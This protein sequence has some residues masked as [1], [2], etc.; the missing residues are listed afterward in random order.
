MINMLLFGRPHSAVSRTINIVGKIGLS[1]ILGG[2]LMAAAGCGGNSRSN[3]KVTATVDAAVKT[4]LEDYFTACFE[5]Q[6]NLSYSKMVGN[7]LADNDNTQLNEAFRENLLSQESLFNSRIDDYQY[8]IAYQNTT[9]NGDEA[10]IA[11]I[12]D[13]DFKYVNAPDDMKS[14]IYNVNYE[15]TLK[16][17]GSQWVITNIESDLNE[18][19]NFKN[20]VK[21]QMAQNAALSQKEALAEVTKTMQSRLQ[22]MRNNSIYLKGDP[23]APSA[24]A[25]NTATSN[26][27]TENSTS[28]KSAYIS[29]QKYNYSPTAGAAYAVTY[30][31]ADPDKRIFYSDSLDCTNFVSQCIWA[32]YVGF[33]SETTARNQIANMIGMVYTEWHATKDGISYIWS[34]VDKLY[35]YLA[36]TSKPAGPKVTVYNNGGHY[37]GVAANS[38]NVG[39]VLQVRT[40]PGTDYAHSVFVTRKNRTV[41]NYDDIYISSHT[42]DRCNVKLYSVV[43]DGFG[44]WFCYMRRL[45]PQSGC[46]MK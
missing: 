17:N 10:T 23:A 21:T 9:V 16:N 46:Y 4:T 29:C 24:T 7:L 1:L 6:K 19:Q 18:Y 14:G 36:D 12:L 22:L 8:Q 39:D 32:G 42:T 34:N 41:S 44:G 28:N 35:E 43:I 38:I 25:E 5:S 2:L 30:A 26:T 40:G 27:T 15:F 3:N 33:S 20:Q 45:V 31:E 11:L 37:T 13:L